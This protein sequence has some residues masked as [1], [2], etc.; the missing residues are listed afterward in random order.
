MRAKWLG[1]T[2]LLGGVLLGSA[3]YAE[4]GDFNGP[5]WY[6]VITVAIGKAV[7]S[8]PFGTQDACVAGYNAKPS[9]LPDATMTCTYYATEDDYYN[10]ILGD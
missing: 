4:D 3:S 1:T 10:D 6:A 9:N 8:G 5:G 7:H 2:I